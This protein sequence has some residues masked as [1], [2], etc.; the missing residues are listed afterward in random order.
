MDLEDQLMRETIAVCVLGAA[1]N[2]VLTRE[3]MLGQA[4]G[5]QRAITLLRE[6]GVED[7]F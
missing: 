2:S 5:L 4:E 7:V 1:S 6:S 3:R